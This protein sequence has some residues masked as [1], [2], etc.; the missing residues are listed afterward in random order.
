MFCFILCIYFF[1]SDFFVSYFF[2]LDTHLIGAHNYPK[3][4]FHC[5]TCLQSF[6][7]RPSLLRHRALEHGEIRKY[8]CENCTKVS[9]L[10]LSIQFHFYY[11]M[12]C[13]LLLF[14]IKLNE[15][16]TKWC[17]RFEFLKILQ[18]FHDWIN[19]CVAVAVVTTTRHTIVHLFTK[20][21]DNLFKALTKILL[22]IIRF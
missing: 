13:N 1:F 7:Y 17:K 18:Y 20:I 19:E 6:C 15:K 14:I 5:E 22:I 2:R 16:F 11:I 9:Y 3:E 21:R 12:R 8:P 4:T 10:I